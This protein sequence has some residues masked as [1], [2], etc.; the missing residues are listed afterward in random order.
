MNKDLK[1]LL[2]KRIIGIDGD[3]GSG[4][5]TSI[6]SFIK[7]N[8]LILG[9]TLMIFPT[10]QSIFRLSNLIYDNHLFKS[11]NAKTGLIYLM[12]KR[13][14]LSTIIIDEAHTTSIEYETFMRT[15]VYFNKIYNYRIYIISATLNKT[16]MKDLFPGIYFYEMMK[17]EGFKIDISYIDENEYNKER[18]IEQTYFLMMEKIKKIILAKFVNH[19]R[20]IVFLASSDQCEKYKSYFDNYN[21][22]LCLVMYRKLDEE[23]FNNT[24]RILYDKQSSFILF[25]TNILETS[26]TIPDISLIIDLGVSYQKRNNQLILNWCDQASMIQRSGRTGRTCNG[27]VIRLISKQHFDEL[28][29]IEEPKYTWEKVI[30]FMKLNNLDPSL[31]IDDVSDGLNYLKTNSIIDNEGNVDEKLGTFLMKSPMDIEHSLLLIKKTDFHQQLIII[32]AVSLIYLIN[33]QNITFFYSVN[34]SLFSIKKKINRIFYHEQ[35][36]LCMLMTIFLTLFL[37]SN[38]KIIAF[39]L[40]LNFKSFRKW[41]NIYYKNLNYIY[42]NHKFCLIYE[43]QKITFSHKSINSTNYWLESI[44]NLHNFRGILS[45]FFYNHT[46]FNII[47]KYDLMSYIYD[48][49]LIKSPDFCKFDHLCLINKKSISTLSKSVI[50]LFIFPYHLKFN[51]N[52]IKYGIGLYIYN[53]LLKMK[54]KI[55]FNNCV[56]EIDYLVSY[57]PHFYNMID[58]I[59]HWFDCIQKYN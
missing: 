44:Y 43:L 36:E 50:L 29:Y 23:S 5:T 2:N 48:G 6:L 24:N 42:P 8:S 7:E 33:D 31:I 28:P 32:L 10:Q 22:R 25:T 13:G 53:S 41:M 3:T 55:K 46:S 59:N 26:I 40:D 9:N 54:N 27:E 35:D 52:E 49:K 39:N 17:S 34:N 56:S 4:K 57:R 1:V 19:S 58:T 20:I 14:E 38:S 12:E 51:L 37:N 16:K 45:E 18:V 15:L 47:N 21:L 11:K 30:L